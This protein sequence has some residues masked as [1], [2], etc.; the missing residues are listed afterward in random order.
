MAIPTNKI[1]SMELNG[2]RSTD[3]AALALTSSGLTAKTG[4][5]LQWSIV[6]KNIKGVTSI[7]LTNSPNI[8]GPITYILYDTYDGES[9][10]YG[11]YVGQIVSVNVESIEHILIT[12][13]QGTIDGQPPRNVKLVLNGCFN[14]E[15]L[16]TKAQIEDDST[17]PS[18]K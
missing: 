1:L 15:Q 4:N 10:F 14:E 5:K 2:Q 18:G 12:T 9:T 8:I 6:T 3:Y 13:S 16:R 7:G 17:T 11:N